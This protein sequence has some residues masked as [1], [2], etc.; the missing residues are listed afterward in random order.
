MA[1]AASVQ[2]NNSA[3]IAAAIVANYYARGAVPDAT[4]IAAIATVAVNVSKAL[5][6]AAGA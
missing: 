5:D 6:T 1:Q 2:S 3:V 4:T